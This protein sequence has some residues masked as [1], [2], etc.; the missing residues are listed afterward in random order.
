MGKSGSARKS[1]N[2]YG[3][4]AG[5]VSWGL[6]WLTAVIGT[7]NYIWQCSSS[8]PLDL[9]A[10][11]ALSGGGYVDLTGGILD[12]KLI[13]PGG[14][15]H[16]YPGI[17]NT[18]SDPALPGHPPYP[19]V[20]YLVA[21]HIFFGQD[22]GTA[23]NLQVIGGRCP[24]V[25]TSIVAAADNI[26]DDR[27]VNP[28]AVVAELLL[29]ERGAGIDQSLF[30]TASWLAAAHWCA[31]DAA[32]RAYSFVSPLFNQQT[33][34]RDLVKAMLDPLNGFLRW[35]PYG[36]LGCY[37]YEWGTDPGNL[38]TLD[39]RYFTNG[40]KPKFKH[41][42]WQDLPTEYVVGFT[43]RAYEFQTNSVSIPDQRV[44]DIRQL[45]D[46]TRLDRP[47]V[48]RAAQAFSHGM[49]LKRRA[50][51]APGTGTISVRG[52][53]VANLQPGDKIK[54][55][56][57]PEPGGAGLAQLAR[58]DKIRIDRTDELTIDLTID[59]LETATPYTPSWVSPLPETLFAGA[60]ESAPSIAHLLAIPLPIDLGGWPPAIGI[61][62][63]RASFDTDG[64]HAY[65]SNVSGGPFTELG[66][67]YGFGV[68]CQLV[69]AIADTDT[70]M[71]LQLLDGADGPDAYI[72][73]DTPGGNATDAADN[74]LLAV[75]PSLDASGRVALDG[76]GQ[77]ILEMA[78]I[79]QRSVVSA[80]TADYTVTRSVFFTNALNWGAGLVVWI[81]PK[82]NLVA[83]RHELLKTYFGQTGYFRVA[84]FTS[85]AVDESNPLPES[86]LVFP[87]IK[88]PFSGNLAPS[89][90]PL[91]N[92]NFS[93]TMYGCMAT[94]QT[95]TNAS[96]A[97]VEM[98]AT[99]TDS[100][101]ATDWEWYEDG[102]QA[103]QG[104]ARRSAT[105][106]QV[107]GIIFYNP[108]LQPGFVRCRIID[109]NGNA[110]AW[111]RLGNANGSCAQAAHDMIFQ[112]S[113]AVNVSGIQTGASGSSSI[114]Q[115]VARYPFDVVVDLVG[116]QAEEAFNVDLTGRGF[117]TKPDGTT[118]AINVS[119]DWALKCRYDWDDVNNS[120]T[121]AV[122]KIS[123]IATGGTT[124]AGS[125]RVTGEFFEY[126]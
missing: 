92:S 98:K 76:G 71:R 54:V 56:T 107:I 9:T 70:V 31:Q 72:A 26:V 58:V 118:G 61:L 82:A 27:Q 109:E 125:V 120:S 3:T 78:S 10:P 55:D 75:L 97:A 117:Q 59:P 17:A 103:G 29:D 66:V 67:Q 77:P 8:G 101:D 89:Q 52:P 84:S 73:A 86:D 91:A 87:S 63:T 39:A 119:S 121:N 93:D 69:N 124:P 94:V 40:K 95:P 38:T 25:P 108:L 47:H 74:T 114:R 99:Y 32:H 24:R 62:A 23:P 102:N 112:K 12:P 7:G 50:G 28:V 44:A 80:D 53:V 88:V 4:L 122:I 123:T 85:A 2:Y 111:L 113:A 6:D 42:D 106:G 100:D 37:I 105:P 51:S 65:F 104:L 46:P 33:A 116:A 5:V 30:D 15:V 83:W 21:C 43:D 36:K 13:M 22:S 20:A 49:E 126:T 79:S 11:G 48:T 110:S 18:A 45:D 34:L 68:R 1:L 60:V 41:R 115:V 19:D 90:Q 64:F 81:I 14:Y 57:D 35:T 96:V 16:L